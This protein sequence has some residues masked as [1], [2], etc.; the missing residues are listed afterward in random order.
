MPDTSI[1]PFEINIP[2]GE[3]EALRQRLA[4]TR[5]PEKETVT[6][7]S[8]GIPLSYVKEVCDYWQKDYDWRPCEK[9]LNELGSFITEIDGLDIH[10]LHCRSPHAGA[11]P[12]IMTH[13]WP[14]SVVE[15][16]DIIP[17][18]TDPVAHGG[19]AEEAFHLVLPTMPGYGFSGKPA[20]TG[21]GVEKIADAWAVLM[22]RL[23]YEHYAAQG[24]AH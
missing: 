4:L 1:R 7:W 12:L 9:R 19:K 2:D 5:W 16:F 21:W 20:A 13:G 14:G 3:L 18:L 17:L 8:Q 6:D 22:Q 24:G 15:F 23:G 10:F 11:R